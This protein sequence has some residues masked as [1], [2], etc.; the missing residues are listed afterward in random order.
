MTPLVHG[1]S[2]TGGRSGNAAAATT[3]AAAPAESPPTAG[4]A[5]VAPN[6]CVAED[7][8]NAATACPPGIARIGS[9]RSTAPPAA[10]PE[11]LGQAKNKGTKSK[12]GDSPYQL[13]SRTM[14]RRNTLQRQTEDLLRREIQLTAQL[15]RSM[16]RND[17]NRPNTLMR[18][19][20]NLQELSSTLNGRAQDLHE[21]IFRAQQA[22]NNGEVQ[23]I[24]R[25]QQQLLTEARDQRAQLTRVFETLV[26]DHPNYNRMDAVLFYLAFAYQEGRNMD[27]ARRVYLLL[28]QRFPQS[29]YVPNAYLSFAEFFFEQGDMESAA[30][31]Y[32]Q[33]ININT[34][35]NN[36]RGYAMYKMAWV[37]FNRTHF[38][39]SLQQ[40]FNVIDYGRSQPDNP[41][42]QPLMRSSRTELVSAYG[43]VYGVSRPLNPSQALNT[44]RRYAADE[45]GAFEMLE[46][47][48]ELYQ[49]NGQWP[50]SISV[51][52]ELQAQRA[53][54]D[55]FCHWQGQ[56]AR[57]YVALN[58]R[59]EMMRELTRL[60]DVYDQY[61]GAS[62]RRSAEA[63]GSCR[64]A[65]ARVVYDVASHWHLEAIGRSAEGQLQTRGTRDPATMT[66][67]AQL[68]NLL[69]EKFPDLDAVTF[70]DYS[71]ADWPTRYRIAYYCADILRDQGNFAE[72]GPAYDR[73]VE[74]NPTGEYTEDAAYKAV[75]CYNDQFTRELAESSRR[76]P[77]RATA[78]R[79]GRQAAP[80]PENATRYAPRDF[81]R[82]ETGM[83][84]AFTRYVCYAT[85]ALQAA[86]GARP[87]TP[88]AAAG[89]PQEDPRQVVM[90]IKYRR[91]YLYYA[92]N[93][94]EEA[95]T[96]FRDIALPS[97][98]DVSREAQDPENLR[99]IAAD[100]YLDT[101]VVM[102]QRWNPSRPACFDAMERDLPLI[103]ERFCGA[104]TRS[105][106]E[107]FCQRMDLLGCQ[108]LRKKAESLGTAR[109]FE[110]AGRAYVTIVRDHPECR[111]RDDARADEMLYNAAV[112]FDSGNMLGRAMRVRDSLVQIF[113]PRNSAWA[114]RA[115][116]RLGGNYHAIQVFGRAADYYERYADYVYGNRAVATQADADAVTQAADALRQ[117]TIFRI[118][119]GEEQKAL[120]NASKFA[121]Y[122]G[123]EERFRRQAAGVVFSI[124]QIYQ[125]RA[126]RFARDQALSVEDRRTRSRGAWQD[127][128]RHY[129][130]FVNRYARNG[131]LDQQIQGNVAL[132]RG[133]LKIEDSTNSTLYFRAAV[134]QWGEVATNA[135]GTR[136][137]NAV[138][139][140][141]TRIREQLR[142]QGDAAVA[143]AIE[144]TRDSAA[145]ARFYLADAVYQRFMS[146]RVPA[147]RG[148][149]S[150]R[151]F[152]QWTTRTLTPYI[153]EQ[154]RNLS[155][156]ATRQFQAVIAMHVPNWEIA[157]AARLADM[158]YQFAQIIRRAPMPPDW[159]RPGEPYETLRATYGAM[160]DE[161]TQPII[162]TA[163]RGY[164]ACLTR[165]TQVH[166]FNEWSQLCERNL[167]EIDR[168]RFPLT[169]EIRSEPN[170][171]FSRFSNARVVFTMQAEDDSSESS[172]PDTQAPA[173]PAATPAAQGRR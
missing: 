23:N 170:L 164:E 29:Q 72:C 37:E 41:G 129:T 82:Q 69:L 63:K 150:S 119:L 47:L 94:F 12:L 70:P 135:D 172:A 66:R 78:S 53:D 140:G 93:K 89:E 98:T 67:A 109:R 107:E 114:Q 159:S 111:A 112:M 80:E 22:R 10:A 126:E 157:A 49:D 35:E 27:Q 30:Q 162:D 113:L 79:T 38:E 7:H 131:T 123:T 152:D 8:R 138:A 134:A 16:N 155:E 42:V 146:R 105:S 86:S 142:D 110:E 13:D 85:N 75:L 104:S 136:V 173:V 55:K 124:G 60:I 15:G 102:G 143:E 24:Q 43:S 26:S 122:F 9:G 139:A 141:E 120:D 50:N 25:R 166:W 106:H 71:R 101:L 14:L 154:Q 158:F 167:N 33:V 57:A 11:N 17:P 77:A 171:L 169:D 34:P 153:Q 19:A 83:F 91:A 165:A 73:V 127:V 108:I 121:R 56:V 100:L 156:E 20:E 161:R 145:E 137:E 148:G 65:T 81:N 84:G 59:D 64:D 128:I 6:V 116:Y 58:R 125:D 88:P 4:V 103:K 28:I 97:N 149:N 44:F 61:R 48:G 96:L 92:A 45:N 21:D 39:A 95:S 18:L 5:A 1:Q 118:G 62:S 168:L 147:Y 32:S 130:G 2:R 163:R 36:V 90:T 46:K 51:F 160:I 31:F 132:G 74:M 54:N 151:A 115:L 76:R 68:Y 133:Y 52:H 87:A 144:K 99:E 3:A 40:F 117:A